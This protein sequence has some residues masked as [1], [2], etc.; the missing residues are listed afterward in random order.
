MPKDGNCLFR[1]IW[2]VANEEAKCAVSRF[3]KLPGHKLMRKLAVNHIREGFAWTQIRVAQ[4]ENRVGK[5]YKTKEEYLKYVG[6]DK[7][8]GGSMEIEALSEALGV[9][10]CILAEFATECVGSGSRKVFILYSGSNHYQAM[11]PRSKV[12]KRSREACS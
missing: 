10:I 7:V 12:R 9:T 2:I 5:Q 11:V 6:R 8:W 4:S 3:G 1:A